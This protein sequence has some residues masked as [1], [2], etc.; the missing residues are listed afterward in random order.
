M[1][2]ICNFSTRRP[3]CAAS[4]SVD[5]PKML[6]LAIVVISLEVFHLLKMNGCNILT[7]ASNK[8]TIAK[9]HAML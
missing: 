4:I 9:N 6:A 7:V 8:P 1:F 5:Y 3:V 2:V